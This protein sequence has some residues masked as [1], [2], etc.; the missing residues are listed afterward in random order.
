MQINGKLG[1]DINVSGVISDLDTPIQPEGT[2]KD[3]D[4]LDKV[5]LNVKHPN[6]NLN[7]GDIYFKDSLRI[8]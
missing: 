5:F 4:E 2:T 8:N 6:F 7:A 1:D 3:L